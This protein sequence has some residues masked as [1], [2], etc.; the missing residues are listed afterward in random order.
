MRASMNRSSS[1]LLTESKCSLM[2]IIDNHFFSG[3]LAWR[4]EYTVKAALWSPT[5][6]MRFLEWRSLMTA[7]AT[8]PLTLNL[9]T[10]SET[11]MVRNLGASLVILSYALVSRKTALLSFSFTLT[12]VQLFFLAFPPALDF[13]P[14]RAPALP[15]LPLSFPAS[16]PLGSAFFAYE[17]RWVI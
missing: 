8:D 15:P 3:S 17:K 16:L 13:L 11:V 6:L 14:G 4:P 10:S 12:L 1:L 9:L 5:C 2:I 7:L